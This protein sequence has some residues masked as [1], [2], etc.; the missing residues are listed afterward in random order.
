MKTLDIKK[1]LGTVGEKKTDKGKW[2]EKV[3]G[4]HGL[5]KIEGYAGRWPVT[6]QVSRFNL[7]K[8]PNVLSRG[9][10]RLEQK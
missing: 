4:S 7:Q 8:A 9:Y 5:E 2:E 1:G 6:E 3:K 10:S